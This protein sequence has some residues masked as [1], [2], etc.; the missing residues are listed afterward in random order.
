MHMAT[1]CHDILLFI[2]ISSTTHTNI[3]H[4][5]LAIRTPMTLQN[6]FKEEISLV[7]RGRCTTKQMQVGHNIILK[8][9]WQTVDTHQLWQCQQSNAKCKA[10]LWGVHT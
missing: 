6:N 1:M 7:L 9:L 4:I 8:A 10:T 3:F 2:T 5:E